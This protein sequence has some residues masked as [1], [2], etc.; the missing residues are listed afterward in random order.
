MSSWASDG[1]LFYRP[2]IEFVTG[3]GLLDPDRIALRKRELIDSGEACPS[4]DPRPAIRAFLEDCRTAG[5]HLVVVPVPDKA[6]LQPAELTS[7]FDRNSQ[8]VMPSNVDFAMFLDELRSFGVDVF[9]PSPKRILPD[10]PPRFLRQDTHWTPEWM[11]EV[12][13]NLADHL[14]SRL[15]SLRAATQS[16][17]VEERHVSR[18]GD[19]VDMLKLPESQHL[20]L[21]QTVSIHRVLAKSDAQPWQPSAEADVLLLGD[22]FSNIYS[23]SDMGWGDSA[24]FPAQ[25][26]RFLKRD[27]DVIARNGSAATATRR[28]LARRP[29][30]LSGKTVIIWEFAARELMHANWEVVSIPNTRPGAIASRAVGSA[31]NSVSPL[32]L[33]GTVV[34]TSRVPQPY[35][36]PYKDCLTCTKLRVDRVVDG[37]LK[38]DHVIAVFWGMR[39]N[40]RLPAADY[41][42]GKRLRLNLVPMRKAP[43]SLRTARIADDLD[44]FERRPFYVLEDRSL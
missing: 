10:G 36:V 11:E 25:L 28:E 19:I 41:S 4:P 35:A 31:E 21:P 9:D 18:L 42:P 40:V 30:P 14:K 29:Q 1:W 34:A 33:E 26:A 43:N 15:P 39:D 7:R 12:A 6:T 20:F 23:T 24:G 37:T 17:S 44:D 16:W 27:V 13:R 22:S 32:V 2:G 5:V 38:D 3:P 8:G